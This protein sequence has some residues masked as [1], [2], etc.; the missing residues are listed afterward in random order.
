[1]DRDDR[2]L[3]KG[4]ESER[5]R[6]SAFLKFNREGISYDLTASPCKES[7]DEKGDSEIFQNIQKGG[8]VDINDA[9]VL[10]GHIGKTLLEK[11]AKLIGWELT[12]TLTTCDA[13]A[14]AKAQAKGVTKKA[15]EPAS[16]PGEG[17][18]LIRRGHTL[19]HWVDLLIG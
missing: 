4:L 6:V 2:F 13:C 1:M 12:D 5:E 14:K 19:H 7:E 16:K 18:T 3:D 11:S 8:K 17:S 15:S 9:H 10:L